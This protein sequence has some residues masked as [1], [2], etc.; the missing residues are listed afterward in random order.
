[1]IRARTYCGSQLMY[2]SYEPGVFTISSPTIPDVVIKSLTLTQNVVLW[3]P[4]GYTEVASLLLSKGAHAGATTL[5]HLTP[6]H[7]ASHQGHLKVARLLLEAWAPVDDRDQAGTSSLHLSAQKGHT[8][9]VRLLLQCGADKDGL[10]ESGWTPLFF[11]SWKGHEAVVRMLLH[12]GANARVSSRDH[13]CF[14]YLSA[15]PLV[16]T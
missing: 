9:V 12:A 7:L 4:Q 11:A 2:E 6:L 15:L 13:R 3:M 16:Q 1:M 5:R 10:D 14:A 8:D